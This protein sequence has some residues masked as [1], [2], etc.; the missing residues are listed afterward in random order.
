MTPFHPDLHFLLRLF[1]PHNLLSLDSALR[2][3]ILR[4]GLAI[5]ALARLLFRAGRQN[6][7]TPSHLLAI[8]HFLLNPRFLPR[9]NFIVNLS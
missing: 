1:A 2:F 4:T 9:L 8:H 7:D 6:D 3:V 5:G